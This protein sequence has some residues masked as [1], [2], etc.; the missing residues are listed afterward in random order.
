MQTNIANISLR[1][2]QIMKMYG[3]IKGLELSIRVSASFMKVNLRV[4]KTFFA[5]SN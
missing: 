5:R 1:N 2:K 4:F 3:R